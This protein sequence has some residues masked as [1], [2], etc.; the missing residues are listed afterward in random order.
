[1]DLGPDRISL[2]GDCFVWEMI[3]KDSAPARDTIE[4]QAFDP[5]F[6]DPVQAGQ[7][8]RDLE[9]LGVPCTDENTVVLVLDV[10]VERLL[11]SVRHLRDKE[12]YRSCQPLV[13]PPTVDS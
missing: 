2:P 10:T 8:V 3:D 4:G 5:M 7:E 13:I 6:V 1:M 12:S 9:R 11:R